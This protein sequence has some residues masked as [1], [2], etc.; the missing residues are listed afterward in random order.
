M[1]RKGE[2]KRIKYFETGDTEL[3]NLAKDPGEKNDLS[4]KEFAVA[5]ELTALLKVWKKETNAPVPTEKNTKY[6]AD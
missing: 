4:K 5:I 1:I 6:K 2:W 3:F